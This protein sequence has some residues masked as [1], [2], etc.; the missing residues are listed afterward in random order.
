METQVRPS[1]FRS[2][3]LAMLAL[4]IVG[5]SALLANV[6]TSHAAPAANSCSCVEYVKSQTGLSGGLG[7]AANYTESQMNARGYKRVSP[8]KG[9]IAVWDRNKKGALGDGHMAI[10][11]SASYNS[12]TKL[13]TIQFRHVNWNYNCTV[14]TITPSWSNLDGI[15]FYVKK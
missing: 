9:A 6:S 13:W 5:G 11:N 4:F 3:M 15:N 8:Q 12:K 14:H 7:A 10:V 1:S 2:A